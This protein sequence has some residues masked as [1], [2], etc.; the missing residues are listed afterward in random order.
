MMTG[1]NI[2]LRAMEPEDIDR[3]L[4]WENDSENWLH[5]NTLRP[6]SRG[7]IER[8]VMQSHDIYTEQQLRLMISMR[9]NDVTI[10]AVDLFDCDFTHSRAGVGIL[11]G[12]PE[13]R[14]K[15]FAVEALEILAHYSYE[16]LMFHQL[17]ADVLS[18]NSASVALFERAGF[19]QCG[20][21]TD[22]VKHSK[23]F[24]DLVLLQ[25]ILDSNGQ[26]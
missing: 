17:Y 11:I 26:K 16:V 3:L 23:G 22:W 19:Q 20:L 2:R 6:F 15:G 25:R 4:A 24:Y 21:R 8:H 13:Y 12:E 10:G 9:E 14:R 5:S 18:N 7:T 1:E